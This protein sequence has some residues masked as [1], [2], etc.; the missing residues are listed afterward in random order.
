M[1]GTAGAFAY[2]AMFGGSVLPSLPPII[3]ADD[4][5][6]KIM[7]NAA[8]AQ[9]SASIQAGANSSGSGDQLVPRQETPVNV[10]QPA[11]AVAPTAPRVVATIPI[12]PTDPWAADRANAIGD[13]PAHAKCSDAFRDRHRVP[14]RLASLYRPCSQCKTLLR[15]P[16]QS[17]AA[18]IS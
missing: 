8:N 18:P 10:P 11:N 16:W 6:T 17:L 9:G 13:G 3:K 2:R 1:L 4:G 12:F 14:R 7:P 5:P 15:L